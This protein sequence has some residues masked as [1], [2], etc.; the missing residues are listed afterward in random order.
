MT[1]MTITAEELAEAL[2][3]AMPHDGGG[4]RIGYEEALEA[5]QK[6]L[7][8]VKESHPRPDRSENHE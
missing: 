5:A 7:E 3:D 8:S 2:C 6:A 4:S 1:I